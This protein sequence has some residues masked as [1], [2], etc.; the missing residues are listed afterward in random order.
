MTAKILKEKKEIKHKKLIIVLAVILAFLVTFATTFF[1]MVKIG[2][3]K[4]RDSLVTNENIETSEDLSIDDAVYYDGEEYYYNKNLVNI[5]LIGVDQE[6]SSKET[7]GQADAIYLV[8][9]DT[10]DSTVKIL[11]V[12]RNTVTDIE[13][14]TD[15][16]ESYGT[17][18]KQI[19]LSY[20]YGNDDIQSSQNCANSVKNL[21]YGVP[22]NGYYTLHMSS[23]ADIVDSVGG[24]RLTIPKD[25]AGNYFKDLKGKTMTLTGKESLSYL[26]ARGDSNAPRLERQKAFI[27]SFVNSA[28]TAV[29]K[30][31]TLPLKMA[32]KLS[33]EAVTN[34]DI[35]SVVYLA[36]QALDWD[37]EMLSIAGNSS[38]DGEYEIFEANEEKLRETVINNFYKKVD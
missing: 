22:I 2:E 21:L 6:D 15:D 4:L 8:S 34:I 27:K 16:G 29:K 32:N 37:I 25:M 12:N 28:K 5:L 23:I 36:T 38:F 26:R 9:V 18:R 24:V 14:L 20:A 3:K 19:C 33:K 31:I 10:K 17:E 7:Q 30:D 35:S 11:G 13:I 1:I